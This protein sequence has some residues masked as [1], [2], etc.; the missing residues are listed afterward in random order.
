MPSF[1]SNSRDAWVLL[2]PGLVR[3]SK[4]ALRAPPIRSAVRFGEGTFDPVPHEWLPKRMFLQDL[5]LARFVGA[6]GRI[7]NTLIPNA[8]PSGATFRAISLT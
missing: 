1:G 8:V 6:T 3:P 4:R 2:S 7:N 5:T